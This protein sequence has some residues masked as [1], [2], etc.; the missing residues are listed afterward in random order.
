M[1]SCVFVC[2]G[3]GALVVRRSL[4][5][6]LQRHKAYFG[7]GTVEVVLPDT[8]YVVRWVLTVCHLQV[9]PSRTA[10]QIVAV[11]DMQCTWSVVSVFLCHGSCWAVTTKAPLCCSDV[12]STTCCTFLL[13]AAGCLLSCRR[14]GAA[15]LEDGTLPFTAIAAAR[16]GFSQL[17]R[18]GG[19]PAVCRHTACLTW[20]LMVSLVQLRHSNGQPVAVLY[21]APAVRQLLEGHVAACEPAADADSDNTSSRSSGT[22]TRA[23]SS[24]SVPEPSV[25]AVFQELQGPVVCFN[26]LRPSGSWVGHKEVGKLAAIHSICLRTGG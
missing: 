21:C 19:L 6:L 25:L 17:Q 14:H 13:S 24:S 15:G 2:I 7:G 3:L 18:L 9:L 1:L 26:L 22:R 12:R 20:H 5:P 8:P 11:T 23:S 10:A 4:L 16:H